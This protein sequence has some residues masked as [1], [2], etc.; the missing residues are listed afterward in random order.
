MSEQTPETAPQRTESEA[1]P[2]SPKPQ[3]P[4][5]KPG[6]GEDHWKQQAKLWE[7]RAR[8]N[9]AELE[10]MQRQWA[11]LQ[12]VFGP[13]EGQPP[14]PE[15]LVSS[16]Q[17][18]VERL[19]RENAVNSLAR[20]HGITDESDIARLSRIADPELRADL[21]ERLKPN[22]APAAAAVPQADPGQGARPGGSSEDE[23]YRRFFPSSR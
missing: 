4:V 6:K 2:A 20:T 21:A 3:A 23:E 14:K 9:L 17:E 19:E 10:P 15:D 22:T 18:R 5:D 7:E 11:A 16:V 1:R 12:Q 8:G 13:A